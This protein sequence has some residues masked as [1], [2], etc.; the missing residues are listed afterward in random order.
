MKKVLSVVLSVLMLC[1]CLIIT[2]SAFAKDYPELKLGETLTIT[3]AK[4]GSDD[5]PEKFAKFIP[6]L[7]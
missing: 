5:E 6:A 2:A 7:C 1:T 4:N 3:M